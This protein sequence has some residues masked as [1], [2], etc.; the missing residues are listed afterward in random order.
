[1]TTPPEIRE[2]RSPLIS[3]VIRVTGFVAPTTNR[4]SVTLKPGTISLLISNEV[5][6]CI[7]EHNLFNINGITNDFPKVKQD[8]I[9][10]LL[11]NILP[12]LIK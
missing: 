5:H 11:K 10:L 12:K 1:M 9:L 6:D 7:P 4:P 8:P 2:S 3:P